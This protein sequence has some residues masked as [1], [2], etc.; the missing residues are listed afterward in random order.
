MDFLQMLV[1]HVRIDLRGRNGGVTEQGL[2]A[3]DVRSFPEQCGSEAMPQGMGRNFFL[4]TCEFGVFSNYLFDAIP[5]EVLTESIPRD[6][7]EQVG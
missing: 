7:Y 3:S 5:A 1:V 4:D 6:T 2:Y